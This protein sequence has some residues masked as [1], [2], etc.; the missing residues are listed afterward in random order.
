MITIDTPYSRQINSPD[1][2]RDIGGNSPASCTLRDILESVQQ[3][4]NVNSPMQQGMDQPTNIGKG[5]SQS[6]TCSNAVLNKIS[7]E[8]SE[9]DMQLPTSE[10]LHKSKI[11]MNLLTDSADNAH[12][13]N[14]ERHKFLASYHI[15]NS[16]LKM[17]GDSECARRLL[18]DMALKNI[19]FQ[20]QLKETPDDYKNNLRFLLG[21]L[22]N[23][24]EE[25]DMPKFFSV[26][27]NL[28]NNK[29]VPCSEKKAV[30]DLKFILAK[31]G[32]EALYSF[33]KSYAEYCYQAW[34]EKHSPPDTHSPDAKEFIHRLNSYQDVMLNQITEITAHHST[35]LNICLFAQFFRDGCLSLATFK[36]SQIPAPETSSRHSATHSPC[37]ANAGVN[38]DG[39]HPQ[40]RRIL[41]GTSYPV[42]NY[43]EN[44]Y[45]SNES[46]PESDWLSQPLGL[47]LHSDLTKN[48]RFSLASKLLDTIKLVHGY[49]T[50]HRCVYPNHPP[51]LLSSTAPSG[52]PLATGTQSK[53]NNA[54]LLFDDD[55]SAEKS[56]LDH[57]NDAGIKKTKILSENYQFSQKARQHNLA[58]RTANYDFNSVRAI[59]S[60][61]NKITADLSAS[62]GSEDS[63]ICPSEVN[64]P[65]VD[66][67]SPFLTESNQHM[68]RNI[69]L[70]PDVIVLP[71][72]KHVKT[73]V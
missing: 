61:R 44:R 60:N 55:L 15:L 11:A 43:G 71:P 63:L 23:S 68:S 31:Y 5:S 49:E 7:I 28:I 4:G 19:P 41:N 46:R 22:A 34:Q 21:V 16:F 47:I 52:Q 24:V 69:H 66:D 33:K 62:T 51:S 10:S 53:S 39:D 67:S 25:V 6:S 9:P 30:A 38:S 29:A 14:T 27:K 32:Q 56:Q 35:L 73:T 13:G 18:D 45:A 58:W 59:Q 64:Y 8:E 26:C 48:Q 17:P 70:I 42:N 57:K 3:E 12:D 65:P 36:Q 20:Q 2:Y 72:P 40:R 50:N 1:S 54:P 37:Q